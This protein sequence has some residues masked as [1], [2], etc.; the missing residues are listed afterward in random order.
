[1]AIQKRKAGRLTEEYILSIHPHVRAGSLTID[2]VSNKQSVEIVCVDCGAVRRVFTSDLHQVKRC[3]A[4]T[5]V[6]RKAAAK[7]KKAE[8]KAAA[9]LAMASLAPEVA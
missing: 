5:K 4:C 1:M 7:A 9:S 8:A 2:A 3:E 6:A